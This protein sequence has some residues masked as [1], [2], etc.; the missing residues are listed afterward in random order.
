M[1]Q[2]Y[3]GLQF[4]AGSDGV[5]VSAPASGKI[6]PPGHYLLHVVDDDGVPSVGAIV[7]VG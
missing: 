7:Q 6:A 1:G 3:V 5:T 2:R 4:T